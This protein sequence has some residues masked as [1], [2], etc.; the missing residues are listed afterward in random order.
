MHRIFQNLVDR[1]SSAQDPDALREVM[2][3]GAVALDLSALHIGPFHVSKEPIH[4][5][6]N[7]PSIWTKHHMLHHYVRIDPVIVQVIGHPE[8]FE[9][10]LG[11]GSLTLSKPQQELFEEPLGLVSATDSQIPSM[12]V[13][14]RQQR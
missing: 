9:R 5:I 13:A 8:P 2:A 7:Y 1:L 12:I 14:V 10:G 3:E 11:V 4:L 6:S